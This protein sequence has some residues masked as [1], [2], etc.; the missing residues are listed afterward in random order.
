M[1]PCVIFNGP[2]LHALHNF[3]YLQI[4]A[5]LLEGKLWGLLGSQTTN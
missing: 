4:L 5:G 3:V 1:L 2:K